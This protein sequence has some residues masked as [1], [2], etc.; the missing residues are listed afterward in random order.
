MNQQ[1]IQRTTCRVCGSNNLTHLFSLGSQYVS[2][3]V[4]EDKVDTGIK[5]PITL[6]L[7][8]NCTLVQQEYTAPQDFLY[9]R[10]YW[11]KSGTTDTMRR[12]LADI[13]S[14]AM[15][16]V[17][18][19][20]GDVVLDIGSNDGTLL[21]Q[22]PRELNLVTVG[23]EPATN[24]K[25]EGSKDI[26]R[27]Q[28]DFWSYDTYDNALD[29]YQGRWF[30]RKEETPLAKIITA[31]GMFY[32][33]ENPNTFIADVAKVLHPDGIFV[34]QLMCLKQTIEQGDIGNLAH[35]H[36]EFY[37]LKSLKYLLGKHGL[38]IVDVFENKVNGGSYRLFIKHKGATT[39]SPFSAE[40]QRI[41]AAFERED[42]MQLANPDKY[43]HWIE[44]VRTQ[45]Q[46]V[47]SFIENVVNE[48]KTVWVYGA[49]TKGNV[50]LQF[51]GLDKSLCEFACDK[52]CEKWDKY[53]CTGIQIGS[54]ELMRKAGVDYLLVLPYAFISEF[55]DREKDWLAKGGT[56]IVP[57]PEPKTIRI[58]HFDYKSGAPLL[59]ITRL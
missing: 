26:S 44:V 32:D 39:K 51:L 13:V 22:Y 57:L 19:A 28:N 53:T 11:Y 36:L 37:S 47:K 38:E 35:E 33:L 52:S 8:N 9:T 6:Q 1:V 45:A 55:I 12:A 14:A 17:G 3:F 41:E 58:E 54:E 46:K 4:T 18:L 10:H 25:E 43:E 56:F 59:D 49:S 7:C 42:E 23:V 30:D 34:A 27:L 40:K 21:R 50:I 31:I 29:Y 20:P 15:N 48:G 5:V 24:M 16:C 2:D